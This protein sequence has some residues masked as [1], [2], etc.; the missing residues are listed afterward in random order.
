LLIGGKK[1][2][3]KGKRGRVEIRTKGVRAKRIGLV[4]GGEKKRPVGGSRNVGDCS[5]RERG[6]KKMGR[7][8]SS[9]T[10]RPAKKN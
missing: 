5:C 8:K 10:R 6:K 2:E 9:G 1:Q 3:T 4:P 7:E